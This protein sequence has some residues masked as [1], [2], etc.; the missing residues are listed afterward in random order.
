MIYLPYITDLG[1]NQLPSDGLLLKTYK[2]CNKNRKKCNV[3]YKNAILKD[4]YKICPYGFSTFTT[5]FC[6]NK[7]IFTSMRIKGHFNKRKLKD[8]I[9]NDMFTQE[10]SVEQF[11]NFLDV[12]ENAL[13]LKLQKI[14]AEKKLKE[15]IDFVEA[16]MHEIRKLNREIKSQSE[17]I[18]I[19]ISKENYNKLENT[20]LEFLK[21]LTANIFSTSSLVSIRLDAYD[22]IFNPMSVTM[23]TK[24]P[25]GIYKKFDK[26][27][28]CLD[29]RCRIDRKKIKIIGNST[30]ELYG[31][32]ILDLLPFVI[33]DNAIKYSPR[34]NDITVEFIKK[35]NS[36]KIEIKNIGPKIEISE[37]D[38]I[39]LRNVRGKYVK[40]KFGWTGIGLFFAKK[41]CEIHNMSITAY[42]LDKTIFSLD[43]IPYSEFKIVIE[44]PTDFHL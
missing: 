42:S 7:I 3:F 2:F 5:T 43:N 34:D 26:V 17:E 40:E 21:D 24:T 23:Q 33:L 27:K 20:E 29:N 37:I 8:K 39:F 12:N 25:M 18:N 31:F 6:N 22:F 35:Y 19:H 13:A 9:D 41:V 16:I 11:E 1:N 4:G 14:D 44:Y 10:L 38:N 28:H 30:T 36:E 32:P 15:N